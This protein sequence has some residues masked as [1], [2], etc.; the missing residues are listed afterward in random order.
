MKWRVETLNSTV[1]AE[2]A[3]LDPQLRAKFLYISELLEMFGPMNV[4]EPYVKPLVDKLWEMRMKAPSGIARAVY[5]T[6]IGRR[7]VVLHV[8]SKK[9]QK[10]PRSAIKTALARAK[11]VEK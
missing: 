5:I 8:F 3:A 4:R 10:T 11:E 1:D 2:L 6:V 7:I 9:T